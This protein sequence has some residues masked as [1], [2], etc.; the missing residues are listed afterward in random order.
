MAEDPPLIVEARLDARAAAT[1]RDLPDEGRRS[2][3]AAWE[4]ALEAQERELDRAIEGSLSLL[5]RIVRGQVMRLLRRSR[6]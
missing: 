1:V 3:Q 4:A 6:T 2:L 5:P